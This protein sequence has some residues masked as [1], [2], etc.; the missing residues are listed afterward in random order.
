MS[1][2]SRA[3][4]KYRL[5]WDH[6]TRVRQ[7]IA[8]SEASSNATDMDGDGLSDELEQNLG[9]NVSMADSDSDGFRDAFETAGG[10]PVD[11]DGDGSIDALDLDSDNDT[12]PDLSEGS[13]D[14]DGDTVFNIRDTDDDGDS[15]STRTEFVDGADHIHD[16]D[17][18]DTPNWLDTDAD[19]DGLPDDEE[20]YGDDDS[21]GVPLYLD[22]DGDNDGLPD[23]Y[24]QDVTRTST[25]NNDSDSTVTERNESSNG[26]VD[27]LEDH[28]GDTLGAFREFA[29][30]TDPFEADTDG[31]G[32]EDGFELRTRGLEPLEQ[33]SDGDGTVDGAE[34]P[35][36]DL[37]N[38]SEEAE[39]HTVL[40]LNDTDG[41]GISD[42]REIEMGTDPSRRDS[43]DD[44]L[45]DSYE[46]EYGTDL[47]NNDTDGDGTLDDDERFERT[48][49]NDTTGVSLQLQGQG[50]VEAEI[51][52]KP[53]YFDG[54]DAKVGPSVRIV[55]RTNFDDATV[56]IPIDES[57]PESEYDSLSVFKWN[58]TTEGSW[59]PINTEV[60]NGTA[61]ANVSTF[62]Y[63]TVVDTDE[64]TGYV[65]ISLGSGNSSREP[66]RFEEQD[67][68]NCMNAC[69]VTNETTLTLGG[70]PET[71]KITVQQGDDSFEVVPLSNGQTIENF[72]DYE[73]YEINSDLPVAKSDSSRLF[74]WSGAKGLSLVTVHDK[75]DD[76]S[77]GA[78]SYD[79]LELPTDNGSWVIA[80]DPPDFNDGSTSPDWAWVGSKTDGGAFRGGLPGQSIVISPSFNAS[81]DR[82]PRSGTIDS[83]EVLTGRATDPRSIEVE[84]N[85]PLTIRVPESAG[86]DTSESD[87]DG[88]TGN[89]TWSY[90]MDAETTGLTL[91][92]QTEQTDVD[93]DA[94][95][96][97]RDEDGSVVRK[98]LSIGTVGTVQETINTSELDGETQF[99]LNVT[100][101]NARV[102]VVPQGNVTDTD[103]DGLLDVLERQRWTM[104]NG[105][106]DEF[107]M[108][109][110]DSD[111]DNDGIPDGD[112]VTFA[113]EGEGE[114]LSFTAKTQSNPDAYDTDGDGLSDSRERN[115]W[116][117]KIADE[118]DIAS[119]YYEAV[120]NEEDTAE[121]ILREVSVS[122]SPLVT[123]TDADNV[124]DDVEE[125]IG[126]DPMSR[127]TDD[128][129]V[130]DEEERSSQQYPRVHDF[131]PPI[132]SG[133][134]ETSGDRQEYRVTVTARDPSGVD[135]ITIA[136][137]GEDRASQ[138][139]YGQE[140]VSRYPIEFEIDRSTGD[141]FGT[142]LS[143]YV[144]RSSAV[145]KTED[146]H[147]TK[148]EARF[149]G[150]NNF[151]KIAEGTAD[152]DIPLVTTFGVIT[153]SSASGFSD[154]LNVMGNGLVSTAHVVASPG[155]YDEV[156]TQQYRQLERLPGIV[157]DSEKR[158]KAFAAIVEHYGTR[159]Q[160]LNPFRQGGKYSDAFAIGYSVGYTASYVVP[161]AG[162]VAAVR[163][164]TR[165][166]YVAGLISASS[167]VRSSIKGAAIGSAMWTGGRIAQRAPDIEF[168]VGRRIRDTEM[169]DSAKKVVGQTGDA[170]KRTPLPE[171]RRLGR[172]F[173][174]DRGQ[175]VLDWLTENPDSDRLEKGL[176]YLR[177]TGEPG[178][179]MLD[180]LGEGAKQRL[181]NM[182]GKAGL[183]RRMTEAAVDGDA[184]FAD[185]GRA[186]NRYD[187][188]DSAEK[189]EYRDIIRI[190]GD[191]AV[192]A[193]GALDD[194]Q[195]RTIIDADV[196]TSQKARSLRAIN[197]IGADN[198]GDTDDG[199]DLAT[200]F[201][202]RGG[203]EYADLLRYDICNSPC[204]EISDSIQKLDLTDKEEDRLM[205]NLAAYEDISDPTA[206][207]P[208]KVESDLDRLAREDITGLKE[209]I[210]H[211]TRKK[212]NPGE[213]DPEKELRNF[214]G[215]DGEADAATSLLDNNDR[216]ISELELDVENDYGKSE[217]DIDLADESTAIEVKN[218]DYSTV[219]SYREMEN[220]YVKSLIKKLEISSRERDTLIIAS[221][222]ESPR[223]TDI[224][225]RALREANVPDDTTIKFVRIEDLS[226]E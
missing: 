105:P 142:A 203:D 173:D 211:G 212:T 24:E 43:D 64:W 118:A 93:P 22:N 188:L 53:S 1:K 181:L 207:S 74:L 7:R 136:K 41:D 166:P 129:S 170:L 31:D 206:R 102:Q 28:D 63:F 191:D 156:A 80:D 21:D 55:N 172:T 119:R 183:Q 178:K 158:Q 13:R 54:Q 51:T 222:T 189:A 42:G 155:E 148:V 68:F 18:N 151:G 6:A 11:S 219:P 133:Y 71:S 208:A 9:T 138:S 127:D 104:S 36:D 186:I 147:D 184:S 95:L 70:T 132:V 8:R 86:E 34:D 143:G 14:T 50:Y 73:N 99:T 87:I 209:A 26:I 157:G 106:G 144:T 92:Y 167:T 187:A 40:R 48:I 91:T 195:F 201:L 10:F 185:I 30:G 97:A 197:E 81:A 193:M 174:D 126:L 180:R 140:R 205:A 134:V 20:G 17:F 37:L 110:N 12:R 108:S 96:V 62:S 169:S 190:S 217:I 130:S 109:L 84:M 153:F 199:R 79:I 82:G 107:S 49:H 200:R 113:A 85:K 182:R 225:E 47:S 59:H 223:D 38:N 15:I 154:S 117:T 146:V 67:G 58:G 32:L 131:R 5:A 164:G 33:D 101:V 220:D 75:P 120:Q 60:E 124:Q 52:P 90:P 103:G 116:T 152:T 25:Q 145:V 176:V 56:R 121:N 122:S 171:Q 213:I 150:T 29:A 218:T 19:G 45:V 221:R 175:R 94:T 165:I 162:E 196:S 226:N 23:F 202:L 224:V 161:V 46:R 111:T 216:T 35:D 160:Q 98:S 123:D 77:G 141:R 125:E 210:K 61:V 177:R 65:D 72:Y 76:G 128:D 137:A 139:F 4:N 89:A 168:N 44:G 115:G 163:A 214:N 204:W 39:K 100:G 27:G 192:R 135:H 179:R 66:L 57:V 88:S 2:H 159:R 3:I 83:W 149:Y 69:G 194:R 215:L 16:A 78:V 112:E 114:N 198:L